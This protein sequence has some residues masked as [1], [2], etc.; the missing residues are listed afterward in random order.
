MVGIVHRWTGMLDEHGYGMNTDVGGLK[1]GNSPLLVI[2]VAHP[3]RHPDIVEQ[4]LM[5]AWQK[6]RNSPGLRVLKIIHGHGSKGKGGSTKETV[7][8]WAFRQR[9]KFLAVIPGEEYSPFHDDTAR[10]RFEIGALPDPD[11]G[12]PNP[13]ITIIWVKSSSQ[14]SEASSQ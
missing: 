11:L 13:G 10:L 8:N 6:V 12:I 14:K 2:D 1:G 3:P 4:E 7:R 9:G 5:D